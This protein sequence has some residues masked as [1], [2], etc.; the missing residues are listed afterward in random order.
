MQVE[1]VMERVYDRRRLHK[2]WQQ[3][4]ANA[5]AAG[6]DKMTVDAFGE[7]EG[8]LLTL[9]HDKLKAGSYRFKPAKRV[10]IPKPGG[11]KKRKPGIPVVMGRVVSQG[12]QGVL[13]EIF[14]P[15]FSGSNFGFRRGQ[16]DHG[17]GW[18]DPRF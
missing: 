8:E 12:L 17:C 5:G 6:V 15:G 14:D 9:I 11:P 18:K 10:L 2:A 4:K 16:P 3:I 13:A 7:R 1:G